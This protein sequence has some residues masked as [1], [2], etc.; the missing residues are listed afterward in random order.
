MSEAVE[1]DQCYF[2]EKKTYKTQMSKP[3]ECAATVLK[4]FRLIF[5]GH[6]G[7]QSVSYRVDTPCNTCIYLMAQAEKSQSLSRTVLALLL[8]YITRS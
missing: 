3:L 7:L 1:A 6:L 8:K 4:N 2:F 5:V